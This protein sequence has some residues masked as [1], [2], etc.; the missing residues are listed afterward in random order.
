MSEDAG[1]PTSYAAKI[2][3]LQQECLTPL[4]EDLADWLNKILHKESSP[5]PITTENFMETLENGVIICHLAKLISKWCE[6][7]INDVS[8]W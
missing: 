7:Q 8:T 1:G 4:K 3:K 2:A 5:N 6:R